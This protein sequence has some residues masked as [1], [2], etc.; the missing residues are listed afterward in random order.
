LLLAILFE[1]ETEE[2]HRKVHGVVF[3][4]YELSSLESKPYNMEIAEL[5]FVCS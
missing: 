3:W 4:L 5:V 2:N 1:V